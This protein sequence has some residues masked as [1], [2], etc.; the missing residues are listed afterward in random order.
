MSCLFSTTFTALGTRLPDEPK[1]VG[2]FLRLRDEPAGRELY[3]A[4]LEEKD[5][6]AVDLPFQ[7]LRDDARRMVIRCR[8]VS[9]EWPPVNDKE[10]DAYLAETISGFVNVLRP[11]LVRLAGI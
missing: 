11:R 1:E 4:L 7:V 6:I 10:V 8:K 2:C 3:Q 9:G 5:S